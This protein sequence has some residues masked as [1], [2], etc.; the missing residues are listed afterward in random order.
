MALTQVEINEVMRQLQPIIAK[1]LNESTSIA[2]AQANIQRG[3]TQ[4]IG[5]RYVPLF[6]DPIEWD[7][8]RAYEP[9]TIVLYQGNSFTTRQYTPAGIEITNEEFWA[10]TGNYNAQVEQYR[11][12]VAEYKGVIDTTVIPSINENRSNLANLIANSAFISL[13]ELGGEE[14]DPSFDNAALIN[15]SIQDNP[16]RGIYVPKGKWYV[17]ST[18]RSINTPIICT[19]VLVLSSNKLTDNFMVKLGEETPTPVSTKTM[20][21]NPTFIV[22]VDGGN[23]Q[24]CGVAIGGF[25]RGNISLFIEGCLETAFD[26]FSRC[27]QCNLDL[28]AYGESDA[29]LGKIGINVNNYLNDMCINAKVRNFETG[30][31]LDNCSYI[32]FGDTHIW[33]CVNGFY[34]KNSAQTRI[35]SFYC[36]TNSYGI[37]VDSPN[38]TPQINSFDIGS[39]YMLCSKFKGIYSTFYKS[40]QNYNTS[41]VNIGHFYF[42]RTAEFGYDKRFTTCLFPSGLNRTQTANLCRFFKCDFWKSNLYVEITP[43]FVLNKTIDEL[44]EIYPLLKFS[45]AIPG[46]VYRIYPC[47]ETA[48][49]TYVDKLKQLGVP[50]VESIGANYGDTNIYLAYSSTEDSTDYGGLKCL[51]SSNANMLA[52]LRL[53]E[54]SYLY[55]LTHTTFTES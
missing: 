5:A 44:K 11:K 22:N 16:T 31:M 24:C 3:V 25:F 4:Y 34:S 41:G 21:H 10:E 33:G 40:A 53:P 6:A 9:L 27:V 55:S 45:E 28:T 39:V 48:K 14:N 26:A 7:S 12:E 15:K 46:L 30:V 29:N 32:F 52:V 19:G 20:L 54:N 49:E 2:Q 51:I 47:E 43:A 38:S 35:N 50:Q 23:T 37:Y 13:K 36:D 1:A 17:H 18:V 42:N 8:S